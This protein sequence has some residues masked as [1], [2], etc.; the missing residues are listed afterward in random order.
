VPA[1]LGWLAGLGLRRTTRRLGGAPV[2]IAL[3]VAAVV[4]AVA[5]DA[6]TSL[7]SVWD[8]ALVGALAAGGLAAALRRARVADLATAAIAVAVSGALL[9]LGARVLLRPPPAFPSEEPH[10]LLADAMQAAQ[11]SLMAPLTSREA[12]CEAIYAHAADTRE[13]HLVKPLA[14]GF[15]PRPGTRA[16]VLH[17][18]DSIPWGHPSVGRFTDRLEELEPDVEH[19]NVSIP[20]TAPDA[21]LSILRRW[22]ATQPIDAVVMHLN[23][24]DVGEMDEPHPCADGRSLLVYEGGRPRLRYPTAHVSSE[25]TRHWRI[26]VASSPP[27][28]PLRA[29]LR[30]SAA[31]AHLAAAFVALSH[32]IAFDERRDPARGLAHVEM[33][34]AAARDELRARHIPFVATLL[35]F[36]MAFAAGRPD[37]A[38]LAGAA[39]RVGVVTLDSWEPLLAAVRRGEDPFTDPSG[40]LSRAGHAVMARWLHEQLGPALERAR[41][42][43]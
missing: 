27:P 34:L 35:H 18:G 6:R 30:S 36:Q 40:H 39:A 22:I 29:T 1:A 21:Y 11:R 14:E 20:G 33:I 17:L 23:P 19:V 13:A 31:A 12:A 25:A 24:N 41:R 15:Q 5:L 16:R 3:L 38:E 4:A 42:A 8:A 2:Q 26:L 7:V 43:P 37:N 9:E 32:R 28:Y 10:L